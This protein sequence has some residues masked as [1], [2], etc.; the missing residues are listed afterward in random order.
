MYIFKNVKVGMRTDETENMIFEVCDER[1]GKIIDAMNEHDCN[2]MMSTETGEVV[3]LSDL[4][5][6]R[7]ILSGL[8]IIDIMYKCK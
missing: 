8:P 5:R 1:I 4:R 7:G 6:V 3:T 2:E